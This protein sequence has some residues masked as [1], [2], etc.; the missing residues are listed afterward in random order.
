VVVAGAD[1]VVVMATTLPTERR[2]LLLL[3]EYG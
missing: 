1:S 2:Y 3:C